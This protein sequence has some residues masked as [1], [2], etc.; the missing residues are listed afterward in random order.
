MKR[1]LSFIKHSSN[2]YV[3]NTYW[4]LGTVLPLGGALVRKAHVVPGPLELR[5]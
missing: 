2:K 1:Y 4:E 5:V 3:L